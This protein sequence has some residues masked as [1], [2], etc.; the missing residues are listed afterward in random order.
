MFRCPSDKDSVKDDN[1]K[2]P[3]D[4][5]D[6]DI[7]PGDYYWD[8]ENPKNVSYSWQAPRAVDANYVNGID[9][10]E[11]EQVILA[12]HDP[13]V[14]WRRNVEA[15]GD[16]RT[17][18]PPSDLQSQMSINHQR[19]QV[20][21]LY[22]AGNVK[23]VKRSDCGVSRDAIY[24]AYGDQRSP[25][26]ARAPI[27]SRTTRRSGIRTSSARSAES[28]R[29]IARRIARCTRSGFGKRRTRFSFRASGY[30]NGE[31]PCF[32]LLGSM[33]FGG[34]GARSMLPLEAAGSLGPNDRGPSWRLSFGPGFMLLFP[35]AVS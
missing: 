7:E 33:V 24:T 17:D 21:V 19:E 13:Q 16:R 14:R 31:V 23:G 12:R 6:G 3:E 5:V 2:N 29:S 28:S 30:R 1:P 8:F 15:H 26:A 11:S 35:G 27:T 20:N 10:D 18:S 22:V 4:S 25:T 9:G 32:P 34:R